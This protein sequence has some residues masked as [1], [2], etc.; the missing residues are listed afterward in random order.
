[1]SLNKKLQIV[2]DW[3]IVSLQQHAPSDI[4]AVSPELDVRLKKETG[5]IMNSAQFIGKVL[6]ALE[7]PSAAWKPEKNDLLIFFESLPERIIKRNWDIISKYTDPSLWNKLNPERNK[8]K[9]KSI[10]RK[11]P[12]PETNQKR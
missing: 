10:W 11:V 7:H 8:I 4:I 5:L 2:F 9:I 1:M 12:T 3:L 6:D